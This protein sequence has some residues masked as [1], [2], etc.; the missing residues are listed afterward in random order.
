MT[1]TPAAILTDTE[2]G[3]SKKGDENKDKEKDRIKTT[4][5][6]EIQFDFSRNP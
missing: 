3:D 5:D 2:E 4:V 6:R 1:I